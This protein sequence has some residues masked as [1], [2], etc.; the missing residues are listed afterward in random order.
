VV[1]YDGRYLYV[2]TW[3]K[4]QKMSWGFF[5]KYCDEAVVYLSSEMLVAGKSL[6]GFNATQLQ[7]DLGQLK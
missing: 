6:E 3:G 2:V 7:A 4:L 1:G 5:R